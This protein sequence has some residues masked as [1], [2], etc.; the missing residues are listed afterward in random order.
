MITARAEAHR[1]LWRHGTITDTTLD[2]VDLLREV[3]E[4]ADARETDLKRQ[5]RQLRDQLTQ[6]KSPAP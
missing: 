1:Y 2:P 5:I 4:E 6:A 3:V